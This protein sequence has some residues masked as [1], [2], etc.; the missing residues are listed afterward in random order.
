MSTPPNLGLALKDA[1]AA[2]QIDSENWQARQQL[3]ET[4]LKMGHIAAAMEAL[5]NALGLANGYDK[6][7]SKGHSQKRGLDCRRP[8]FQGNIQV[9][10]SLSHS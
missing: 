6:T 5:E 10:P 7:Q 2:I 1:N 9:S 3:G 8:F 4:R